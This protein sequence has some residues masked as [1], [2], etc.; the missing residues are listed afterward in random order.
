MPRIA[1]QHGTAGP[2]SYTYEVLAAM[3]AEY[4][5]MWACLQVEHGVD[6]MLQHYS[7]DGWLAYKEPAPVSRPASVRVRVQRA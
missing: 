3:Q 5:G 6:Q 1:S 7:A 4:K 2:A